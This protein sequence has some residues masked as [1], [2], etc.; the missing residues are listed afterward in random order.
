[1]IQNE[2]GD[3]SKGNN[4]TFSGWSVT[5]DVQPQFSGEGRSSFRLIY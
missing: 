1:M 4:I 3:E 2:I 5:D